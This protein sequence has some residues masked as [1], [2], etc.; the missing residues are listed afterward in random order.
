MKEK[1]N[2][3]KGC[4]CGCDFKKEVEGLV[5][6]GKKPTVEERLEKKREVEA[7]FGR[8]RRSINSLSD[9]S[10]CP[11][12]VRAAVP[13]QREFRFRAAASLCPGAVVRAGAREEVGGMCRE[14]GFGE[15]CDRIFA[16]NPEPTVRILCRFAIFAGK[17]A[18]TSG[19]AAV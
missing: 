14:R 7:A 16:G 5:K 12:G 2:G 6:D 1:E 10:P 8:K 19:G 18:P 3:K 11:E 13:P 15:V 4:G 9:L 17:R